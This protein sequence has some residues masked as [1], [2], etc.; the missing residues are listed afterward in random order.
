MWGWWFFAAGLRISAA[1]FSVLERAWKRVD[2]GKRR[3]PAS[4]SIFLYMVYC[5]LGSP[6]R[7]GLESVSG[8]SFSFTVGCTHMPTIQYKR[9]R[10]CIVISSEKFFLVVLSVSF[11]NFFW[12]NIKLYK[13]KWSFL[14]R[15]VF[16]FF[17]NDFSSWKY[18]Q[19]R[20]TL[21]IASSVE[22]AVACYIKP[23]IWQ[24]AYS[25]CI[26]CFFS[27]MWTHTRVHGHPLNVLL[28]AKRVSICSLAI[29][30]FQLYHSGGT[31]EGFGS[32]LHPHHFYVFSYC[33]HSRSNFSLPLRQVLNMRLSC[34]F[35]SFC[36]W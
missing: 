26:T 7:S 32:F 8:I 10:I 4:L 33:P 28:H 22:E 15:L 1:S 17:I 34:S 23:I 29:V 16:F 9:I 5:C 24:P 19:K 25:V 20:K 12:I 27:P 6:F 11:W 30:I 31:Q 18:L 35:A 2:V 14:F 3:H 36:L 13:Y 21:K